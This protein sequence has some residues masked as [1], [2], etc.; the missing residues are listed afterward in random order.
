M[1][2]TRPD[3]NWTWADGQ[4]HDSDMAHDELKRQ[5]FAMA[6]LMECLNAVHPDAE[7]P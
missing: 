5:Y 1:K 3:Q 6:H 2:A 7:I 4:L